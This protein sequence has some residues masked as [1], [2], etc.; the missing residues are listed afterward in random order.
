MKQPVVLCYNLPEESFRKLRLAAM[1]F[2]IRVRSV[3]AFEYSLPLA[4]LCDQPAMESGETPENAFSDPML[5]MAYFPSALPGSF[6][7]LLR[8]NGVPSIPLKAILTPTNSEWN[9]ITLHDEIAK[10]REAI[11]SGAEE[12]HS[13]T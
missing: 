7:Q 2:K 5:V 3:K 10:E 9:S 12:V 4:R 11:L 13:E 6:L 8:K 1:R